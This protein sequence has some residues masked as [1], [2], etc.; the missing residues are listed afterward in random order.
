MQFAINA[1]SV[2]LPE[3]VKTLCGM[4]TNTSS[5]WLSDADYLDPT[6][7]TPNVTDAVGVS[8]SS[9]DSHFSGQAGVSARRKCAVLRH[10]S[11]MV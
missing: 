10:S 8:T 2:A 5:S 3:Q 1:F 11:Q 4:R 9:Y 6:S 7:T